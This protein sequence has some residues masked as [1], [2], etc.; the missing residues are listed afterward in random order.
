[1]EAC[2]LSK[3]MSRAIDYIS[4]SVNLIQAA[5]RDILDIYIT[6]NVIIEEVTCLLGIEKLRITAHGPSTYGRIQRVYRTLNTLLFTVIGE[7]QKD[8]AERLPMLVVAYNAAKHETT[9]I[10]TVLSKVRKECKT[11][12]D[13][14]LIISPL[15]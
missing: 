5:V 14:R 8:R 12:L 6:D 4:I 2:K 11:L 1:M 10:F 3:Q 15:G 9:E 7:N 13:L